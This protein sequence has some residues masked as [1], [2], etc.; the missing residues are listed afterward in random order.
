MLALTTLQL[1]TVG[2][3]RSA[4]CGMALTNTQVLFPSG[5]THD[6]QQFANTSVSDCCAVCEADE[7]CA[8]FTYHTP[9][10]TC[11]LHCAGD[12]EYPA[13]TEHVTGNRTIFPTPPDPATCSPQEQVS[14][15]GFDTGNTG[16][17]TSAE[18]CN[19]CSSSLVC[20]YFTF[21]TP[22]KTCYMKLANTD[23]TP[24]AATHSCGHNSGQV[25]LKPI[26]ATCTHVRRGVVFTGH[27]VADGYKVFDTIEQCCSACN[28]STV[29]CVA[30]SYREASR[31]CYLRDNTTGIGSRS[32]G[33]FVSGGVATTSKLNKLVA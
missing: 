12:A 7:A 29:G 28:T 18:C 17:N 30:W 2:H 32:D 25:A 14:L 21:H 5:T 33:T 20:E 23:G 22:S 10:N 1:L 16:V 26:G 9:N 19:A 31:E 3:A 8:T 13:S 24:P 6:L 11:Y 15:D 4:V 27:I